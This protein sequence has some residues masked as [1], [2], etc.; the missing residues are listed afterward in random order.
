MSTS[1]VLVV[2][3]EPDIVA[4]LRDWLEED[5]HEVYCA[6]D[7]HQALR[8]FFEHRPSLS[9]TDLRM[10]GMDGFELISLIRDMSDVHV[11]VLSALDREEQMIRGLELGADEYLVKPVS[12]NLFLARVRSLLRRASQTEEVFSDRYSDAVLTIDFRTHEVHLRSQYLHVRPT[13]FRVLSFL[14]KNRDRVVSREELLDRVWGEGTGSLES[15][16]WH[17]S[18][19]RDK[20]ED[21]R[22]ILTL[23]RVGYRYSPPDHH[24]LKGPRGGSW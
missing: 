23:A 12:R 13:E 10:P 8:L 24:P 9:V 16:K 18:S 1:K 17:I 3:D 7:G 22:L 11:L 19:L 2:D 14:V 5:G 4:V 21:P 6:T 15:L 20:L